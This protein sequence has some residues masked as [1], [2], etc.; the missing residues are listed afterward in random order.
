MKKYSPSIS[1]T[2]YTGE[3]RRSFNPSALVP[4]ETRLR[5]GASGAN[6]YHIP[7]PASF[8]VRPSPAPARSTA[9][10]VVSGSSM[11]GDPIAEFKLD[12]NRWNE[13]EAKDIFI[14]HDEDHREGQ[15]VVKTTSDLV[16]PRLQR[17]DG[18][19]DALELEIASPRHQRNEEEK[20]YN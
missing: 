9:V 8:T 17:A 11:V 10:A 1:A 14:N 20:M 5:Q 18:L 19:E 3:R 15:V 12:I 13:W 16:R 2:K 6:K 4:P 7:A